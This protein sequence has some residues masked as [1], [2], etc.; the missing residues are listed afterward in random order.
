MLNYNGSK[1]ADPHPAS[2]GLLTVHSC[3]P[4]ENPERQGWVVFSRTVVAFISHYETSISGQRLAVHDG[5]GITHWRYC[6]G[7]SPARTGPS[8]QYKTALL[9]QPLSELH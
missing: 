9:W 8:A 4:K 3:R 1:I 6:V 5:I 2:V 7:A